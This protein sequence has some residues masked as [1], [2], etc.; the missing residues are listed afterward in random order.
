M[1][2]KEI[3]KLLIDCKAIKFGDFILTSG[4]HSDYYIDIKKASTNPF[5]LD[6]ITKILSNYSKDYDIIAG[7]ELGAVPLI[8]AL[9]LEIKK[10]F[11]IIRKA[12][13]DHGTSK[14]IEGD[15]VGNKKVLIIEDVTT[16]GGSVIEAIKILK[17]EE[18]I[19][20][21]VIVIV[22]R[23]FG[24]KDKI[25]N[26]GLDLIPLLNISEIIKEE[27]TF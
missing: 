8:V 1:N 10:P 9:S 7:M 16:S 25:K 24:A 20:D 14:Q 5:I 3:I 26:F 6:K 18:A 19:V 13:R 23:E 15:D 11:V 21:K 2:K 12:K 22:D 4:V 27:K 17:N